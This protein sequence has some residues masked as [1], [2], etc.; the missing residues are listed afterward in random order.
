MIYMG[1][2]LLGNINSDGEPDRCRQRRLHAVPRRRRRRRLDRRVP[3]QRR[4]AR[5]P[6]R[7]DLR[8]GEQRRRTGS[9]CITENYGNEALEQGQIT[10]FVA[11]DTTSSCPRS[12]QT[13]TGRRSRASTDSVLWFEALFNAKAS[14]I[15]STSAA[16]LVTGQ[17]TPRGVHDRGPGPRSTRADP[18]TLRCELDAARRSVILL[19]HEPTAHATRKARPHEVRPRRP[20]G[21]HCS[22]SRPHC[23]ST[24]LI[25]LVPVALVVRAHLLHGQRPRRASSSPASHNFTRLFTDPDVWDAF[26]FTVKYAMLVTLFQVVLGYGLALLYI[27]VLR[28]SSVLVRTLV[29]FPVVLPT[30]AVALL[31]QKLFQSAPADGLVNELLVNVG[32]ASVDWLGA[33]ATAFIVIVIMDVWRS[34]GF[35]GVLLFSGLLDIPDEIIESARIDGA[36]SVQ[37]S[38]ATSSCRCRCRSCSPRSSSASTAR[39]RSSTRS[40]PSPAAARATRPRR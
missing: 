32:L 39:S 26:W 22:C 36:Q 2:W 23:S 19:V 28:K 40:S 9:K 21:D 1:S 15:S 18:Q 25:M 7:E 27:F 33:G 38:S 14:S 8:D 10:G 17:L 29:F 30:V 24:P 20:Q 35:Y 12:R 34:V 37:A 13:I 3:V 31:Y 16:L 4:P 6:S 11:D 5:R